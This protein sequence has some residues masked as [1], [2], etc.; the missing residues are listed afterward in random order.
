[1]LSR[2]S[3]GNFTFSSNEEPSKQTPL[4]TFSSTT[5]I[6]KQCTLISLDWSWEIIPNNFRAQLEPKKVAPPY[7][8]NCDLRKFRKSFG[9][10]EKGLSKRKQFEEGF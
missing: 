2:F 10:K 3:L 7:F 4:S 9:R 1:M 6:N 5:D 8:L